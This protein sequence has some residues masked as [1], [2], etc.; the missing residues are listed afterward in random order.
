[1]RFI[2]TADWHLGCLFY[3]KH[4]T[5]DQGYVLDQLIRLTKDIQPDAVIV[6]GDV[7]DRSI[8]P[9]EAVSLL[10][11]T[12]YRLV[13]E[14]HVP[15]ILI[16]GNHDSPERTEYGSRLLA[17]NHLHILGTLSENQQPI[18]LNDE[19]G[20]VNFYAVPYADPPLFR[21]HLSDPSLTDHDTALRAW[22]KRV[23]T[24]QPS[25]SRNVF[26]THAFVMGGSATDSERP[27]SV[28]GTS[29]VSPTCFDGFNYVALGHLHRPQTIV[30]DRIQYSGSLLKY[31]FSEADHVKSVS[32]V[33]MDATG[34]CDI[35][36]VP[37]T[38]RRDVR[39]VKGYMQELLKGSSPLSNHDDY[40]L[41]VLLD[42]GA[43]L[44]PMEQ[45]RD[46][47]PNILAI[48]KPSLLRSGNLQIAHQDHRTR[49]EESLFAD[50]FQAMTGDPLRPEEV[51]EVAAVVDELH[52]K[53]RE[54]LV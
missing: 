33:H 36:R 28:G 50:F 43:L 48:E 27:L 9:P 16:A 34:H 52:R 24:L 2:H 19:Y 26:I 41:A 22:I 3:G 53:Q 4:L 17:S 31:S 42:E 21:E 44:D 29:I 7:F 13:G 12:L 37:L 10:D 46:I 15:V 18:R 40:V 45:L 6:A 25:A 38:P 54:E 5:D 11:E 51:T 30:N 39:V 32:I 35:E 1:M 47:Y 23:G 8:P 14:L 49:T 20:T